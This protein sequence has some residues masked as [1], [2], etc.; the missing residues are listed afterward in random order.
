MQLWKTQPIFSNL[1]IAMCDNLTSEAVAP[2]RSSVRCI[3]I[4]YR[5]TMLPVLIWWR[6]QV[7]TFSA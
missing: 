3:A 1:A 7:E 4:R 2:I 5:E 6:H